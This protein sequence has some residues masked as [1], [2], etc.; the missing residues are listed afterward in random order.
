[1]INSLRSELEVAMEVK[2]QLEAK[3]QKVPAEMAQLERLKGRR[4]PDRCDWMVC[5]VCL[6]V[7]VGLCCLALFH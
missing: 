1:V 2:N 6:F 5:F 3:M 4:A 7:P